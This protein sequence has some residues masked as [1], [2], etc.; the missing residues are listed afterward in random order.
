MRGMAVWSLVNEPIDNKMM[1]LCASAKLRVFVDTLSFESEIH[2]RITLA[3]RT[4]SLSHQKNG[5]QSK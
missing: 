5:S 1:I 2:E 3:L 4:F